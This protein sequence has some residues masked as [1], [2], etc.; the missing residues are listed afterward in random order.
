ISEAIQLE[1]SIQT[2]DLI[3]TGE[4]QSDEQTLYGKAPGYIAD[5]GNSYQ[6]PTILLSGSLG[7]HNEKLR[8]RFAG[9]FSIVNKPLSLE[10]CMNNSR[11]L[12]AE[13]TK[14]ILSLIQSIRA[15]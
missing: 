15:R 14:Q 10:V 4:G 7:E 3:I 13:Q 9:C 5:I 8:E 2:A 1:E 6:V 11:Q 12:L